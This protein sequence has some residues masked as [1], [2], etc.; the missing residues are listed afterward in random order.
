MW[1]PELAPKAFCLCVHD[2]TP[3]RVVECWVPV[4]QEQPS[5]NRVREDVQFGNPRGMQERWARQKVEEGGAALRVLNDYLLALRSQR[6]GQVAGK[7]FSLG[8]C[9]LPAALPSGRG[10]SSTTKRARP[11][12][13]SRFV[14]PPPCEPRQRSGTPGAA[15]A[16]ANRRGHQAGG[17]SD[18]QRA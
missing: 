5:A 9:R 13:H 7:D 10:S 2:Q 1:A 14:V 12:I 4:A 17:R 18:R 15:A 16:W 3:A 6:S 8:P 11:R